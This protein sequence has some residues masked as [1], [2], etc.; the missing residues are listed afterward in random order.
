MAERELMEKYAELALKT[1]VNLQKNQALMINASIEGADFVRIVAR[2]AW[3]MGAKNVHINWSDD[4][5]SLLKFQNAPE[6]TLTNIPDWQI[7]KQLSFAEDGAALLSIS[8]A[9]P[10]LL[11]DV[12]PSR[13]AKANKASGEALKEFRK[14]IMNDR[15]PWSIISIP[16]KVWAEKIFPD[17]PMEEAVEQLWEQIFHIVRVDQEDP[18]AAW[19]EHNRTLSKACDYLNGKAYQALVFKSEGTDIRFG[20]PEGHIWK[21]GG[22]VIPNGNHFNPNMPTE[23]VFTMPNKYQVD[24]K[25]TATKPLVYGGNLIDGFSLTFKD[26][27]VVDFEAEQG[28]ETLKHLL[29][30]DEGAQRLG[31]LALV[32]HASPISQS[33]LIF[34]HTLYDE[35]ASCHVALGKAYPTNLQGGSDMDEQELDQ[36][37]VND[38]LVHVD[39]MIGSA[40]LDIDGETADGTLEPVFRQGAWAISFD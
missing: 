17:L 29:D 35:N 15:I 22:A 14:Y 6:E 27:K 16:T 20:L 2:K 13:I 10:D 12:D 26:G 11:K 9:N 40:D 3:E 36:H 8:S 23:E 37:G 33:D 31:E 24:G 19:D 39:F 32:P 38:S 28:Y 4:E 30:T 5:L 1:G 21:G 18:I 34:F 7:A 25:V